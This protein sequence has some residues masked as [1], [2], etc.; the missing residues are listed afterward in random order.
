MEQVVKAIREKEIKDVRVVTYDCK[1]S[2][3][4]K[5][6]IALFAYTLPYYIKVP[7]T[8]NH[9]YILW[10]CICLF[11]VLPHYGIFP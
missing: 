8:Q 10:E 7:P 5:D 3:V 11:T 2:N 6:K 1:Y 4:F 9:S